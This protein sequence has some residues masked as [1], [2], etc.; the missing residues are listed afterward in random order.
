MYYCYLSSYNWLEKYLVESIKMSKDFRFDIALS[1]AGEDRDY[2]EEV[3]K[4]LESR[5][6]KVH[7]DRFNQIDA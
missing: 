1:F 4:I 6:I 5:G 3:A 2:V 7:Y